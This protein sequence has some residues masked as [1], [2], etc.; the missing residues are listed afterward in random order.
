MYLWYT[1]NIKMNQK[2]A[3]PLVLNHN[4]SLN[5]IIKITKGKLITG[6]VNEICEN[7]T[8]DSREIKQ[9]DVYLGI[10]GEKC[11]GSIYF[12][13]AFAKGAK[14]AIL[15]EIEIAEEQKQKYQDKFI[16]L[17][18]DTLKAICRL[19]SFSI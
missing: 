10:K 5:D 12:E 15:Q 2:E 18:E 9:V 17:V 1:P 13:E 7:F 11:N 3:S 14:G 16:L 8:R 4:I 19:Q 6:D